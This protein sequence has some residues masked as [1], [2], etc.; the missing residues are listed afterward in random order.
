[1]MRWPW[2]RVPPGPDERQ[3]DVELARAAEFRRRAERLADQLQSTLDQVE[4]VLQQ[5]DRRGGTWSSS[6]GN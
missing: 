3:R 4:L 2:S 5:H 6:S 1:M